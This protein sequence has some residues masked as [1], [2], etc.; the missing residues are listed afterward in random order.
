MAKHL[1]VG[2]SCLAERIDN[3]AEPAAHEDVAF[4]VCVQGNELES[5]PDWARVVMVNGQGVAKSRN[6]AID[7]TEGRYLL[8]CDDDVSLNMPGILAGVKHLEQSSQAIV[9]GQGVTPSGQPRKAYPNRV[10]RLTKFNTAKTA[11]YEMLIDVTQVRSAGIRFDERFGAGTHL[12]LADEYIFVVDLLRAGLKGEAIQEVFGTHPEFSSGDRWEDDHDAHV[13]A[14]AL[15]HV[16]GRWSPFA[17]TAFAV[18]H[19]GQLGDLRSIIN[20]ITDSARPPVV[21][22]K[23]EFNEG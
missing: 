14:V 11:T 9:L 12:Q 23:R 16:F 2:Y 19:M 10:T 6:A 8:F 22:S 21:G 20:F 18:K 15:N 13:R 7:A 5:L 4:V 1:T 3:I 17:R